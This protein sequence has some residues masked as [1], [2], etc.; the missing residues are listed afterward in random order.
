MQDSGM[1]EYL[2][3][4]TLKNW[5]QPIWGLTYL[6]IDL[7][8]RKDILS[9]TKYHKQSRYYFGKPPAGHVGQKVIEHS[10][11]YT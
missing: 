3:K 6:D 9:K 7:L 1:W 5:T 8:V 11:N 2:H 10:E 4:A